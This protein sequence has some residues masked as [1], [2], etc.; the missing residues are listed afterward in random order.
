MLAKVKPIE[1][2]KPL[3][4]TIISI[5]LVLNYCTR[6]FPQSKNLIIEP[7]SCRAE[8]KLRSRSSTS[9]TNV[10]FINRKPF[11]VRVYWSDFAGKRKHYFDLEPNQER[12]QQTFT[13]H[14]WV[15]TSS[16]KDRPCLGIFL[17]PLVTDGV[18]IID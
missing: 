2:I 15:I 18:A 16:G 5:N 7:L 12:W 4:I 9:S 8:S 3:T 13:T 1:Y 14:P 10:L 6:V 11:V 17:P